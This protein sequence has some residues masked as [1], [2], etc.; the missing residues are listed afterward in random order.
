MKLNA[1]YIFLLI[2]LGLVLCSCLGNIHYYQEPFTT[3]TVTLQ[4]GEVFTDTSGNTITVITNT[5]GTQS[6][7]LQQVGSTTPMVLTNTSTDPTT[8]YSVGGKIT[9][10]AV[11]GSYGNTSIKFNLPNGPTIIFTNSSS[12]S[13]LFS[14]FDN[15]NHYTG[16]SSLLQNGEVFIDTSGNTITVVTNSNGTQSLQVQQVGSTTPMVL[17]N[18]STDPT[19]YYSVGGKITATAVTGSNGN[20]II[21]FNLPNGPTIIFTNSSNSSNSSNSNVTSTQYYGSTGSPIQESGYSLA[22][23]PNN[24]NSGALTGPNGN[25]AYYAQGPQG[26]T[27]VGTTSSSSMSTIPYDYSN[28]LPPGI[29][30]SQIPTGQE[31]LYILKSEVVPPVCP[32]CPAPSCTKQKKCQPCPACARCPEPSFE[33][34]KVPNYNAINNEYLPIPVLNS[35]S[36]FGM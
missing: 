25:T 8:Y 17:T 9:A 4:N 28:S 30:A 13:S 23:Q 27:L 20:T 15:Y 22:Y 5:N 18:T 35:F 3:S 33:C 21:K 11:T 26:N 24:Y 16:S 14:S 31:N 12:S 36:S 6:L 32:A 7:Q 29:P 19:T 1:L 2:L 10:T 34:K